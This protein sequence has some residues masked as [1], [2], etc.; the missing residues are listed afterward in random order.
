MKGREVDG[1]REG[2]GDK[3][4]KEGRVLKEEEGD[5]GRG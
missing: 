3:R 1:E 4:T 5:R 2:T